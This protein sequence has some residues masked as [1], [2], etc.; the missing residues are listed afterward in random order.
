MWGHFCFVARNVEEDETMKLKR[1]NKHVLI[2][3]SGP[4]TIKGFEGIEKRTH[5]Q[6][7]A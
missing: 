2:Y 7:S 5:I 4:L 6:T 3:I 1:R